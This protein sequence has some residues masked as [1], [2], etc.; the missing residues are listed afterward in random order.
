MLLF[1]SCAF[2]LVKELLLGFLSSQENSPFV[3]L[4]YGPLESLVD[5]EGRSLVSGNF[6]PGVELHTACL[7]A[8]QHASGY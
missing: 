7:E 6:W 2:D 8:K 5:T 3:V 4:C 1:P